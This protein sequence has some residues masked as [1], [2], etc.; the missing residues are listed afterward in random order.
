MGDSTDN[1]HSKFPKTF[2][3]KL[4]KKFFFCHL[5]TLITHKSG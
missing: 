2:F 5:M 1:T 3:L 4:K